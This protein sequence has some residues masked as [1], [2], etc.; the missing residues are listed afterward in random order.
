MQ[1]YGDGENVL[2]HPGQEAI[3]SQRLNEYRVGESLIEKEEEYE[4]ASSMHDK[5]SRDD[6]NTIKDQGGDQSYMRL[7]GPIF[8]T[9]T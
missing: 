8:G 1:E 4:L 6:S 7:T 2:S 3:Q 9:E 5:V